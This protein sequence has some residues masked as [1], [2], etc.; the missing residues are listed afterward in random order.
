MN[1]DIEFIPGTLMLT[2]VNMAATVAIAVGVVRVVRRQRALELLWR[3]RLARWRH[4]A[5][6]PES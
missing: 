1:F 6:S 5:G 2:T 4:Q 3:M